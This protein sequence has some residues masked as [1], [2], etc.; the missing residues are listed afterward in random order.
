MGWET[1]EGHVT[2]STLS[3]ISTTTTH[4]SVSLTIIVWHITSLIEDPWGII[5][6]FES[7]LG[8]MADDFTM[9][10]SFGRNTFSSVQGINDNVRKTPSFIIGSLIDGREEMHG[11][12]IGS[13]I[14]GDIDIIEVISPIG[15]TQVSNI[16]VL[17]VRHLFIEVNSV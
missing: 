4:L 14:N 15:S 1:G 16:G 7:I 17:P 3:E 9:V 10:L 5:S 8:E 2:S 13:V 6:I 12:R 11:H